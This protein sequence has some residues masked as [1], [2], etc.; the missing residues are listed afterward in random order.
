MADVPEGR[1]IIFWIMGSLAILF[2]AWIAG[3]VERALGTTD[4]SFILALIVAFLLILFGGFLWIAVAVG[5]AHEEEVPMPG[6]KAIS[7]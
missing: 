5:V 3:N 1:L 4:L 6:K 7:S 2:G